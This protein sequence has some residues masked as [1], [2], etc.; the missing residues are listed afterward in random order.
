MSGSTDHSWDSPFPISPTA[1]FVKDG[2]CKIGEMSHLESLVG[3]VTA[4]EATTSCT[5]STATRLAVAQSSSAWRNWGHES[6]LAPRSVDLAKMRSSW[7]N[8]KRLSRR[9]QS[10]ESFYK[11]LSSLGVLPGLEITLQSTV[12]VPVDP[13]WIRIRFG[14]RNWIIIDVEANKWANRPLPD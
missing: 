1:K 7:V 9:P 13:V 11:T 6:F 8:V 2:V 5:F 3:Q 4:E 14:T 12:K 10:R